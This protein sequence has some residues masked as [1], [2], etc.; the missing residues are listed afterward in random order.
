MFA[1]LSLNRPLL[2]LLPANGA[3]LVVEVV[4]DYN[5][6]ITQQI[7]VVELYLEVAYKHLLLADLKQ[8]VHYKAANA[9]TVGYG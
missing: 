3:T 7:L 4:V 8:G 1:F 2:H 6:A 5:F 9:A